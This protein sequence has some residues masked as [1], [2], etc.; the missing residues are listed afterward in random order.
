MRKQA[1]FKLR[2][3]LLFTLIG[4]LPLTYISCEEEGIENPSEDES[5]EQVEGIYVVNEGQF[6]SNNGSIT[7][8]NPDS[9][10]VINDYFE[11]NNGR[12]PGDV[13]QDLSFYNGKGYIVA[14]NSKNLA[15]I[16]KESFVQTGIID[17]LSFP[18]QFLAIDETKGYLTNGS[19]ADS[20]KGHVLVIDLEALVITDS[21][22]VGRGPE[23]MVKTDNLVFVTNSGGFKIDNTVSIIDPSSN[24]VVKTVEVGDIPTDITKDNNDNIWVLCKG[25][26]S[27][28]AGGPTNSELVKI[29]SD[30]YKTTHFD[31]GKITSYGNY[32]L[33][34]SP[35]K[36]TLFYT[37]AEGVYA[38][39]INDSEAPAEPVI[40]QVPYG[41]DINPENGNIFCLVS[42]YQ[43]KGYAFRYNKDYTL[44]DS[45]QVGYNPNAVVFE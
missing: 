15:V 19:S 44:T 23:C 10:E 3:T 31:L 9:A 1:F 13:V 40:N 29:H 14:N 22:E 43:A 37:G 5:K 34:M 11:A 33:A 35:N 28:Q 39:N 17:S 16:D 30:D 36:D 24:E 21:I 20:S 38:M 41:L 8:I 4:F 26:G 42:S 25:R 27:Y 6:G 7:L 12:T 2:K 18:R 32:L 45:V